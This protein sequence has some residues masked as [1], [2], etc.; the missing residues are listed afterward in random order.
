MVGCSTPPLPQYLT[1]PRLRSF[2]YSDPSIAVDF[3]IHQAEKHVE[4]AYSEPDPGGVGQLKIFR[5][6]VE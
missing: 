6:G 2:L 5:T 1:Y 4:K 3:E